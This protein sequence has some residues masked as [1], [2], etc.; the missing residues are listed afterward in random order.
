MSLA[1]RTADL[2]LRLL[3]AATLRAKVIAGNVANQN[4][5]SYKRREVTFE[6]QLLRELERGKSLEELSG[7]RPVITVDK[8]AVAR[9]DGNSVDMESEVT[10]SRENRLLYELYSSILRGQ[11]RLVETAIRS[12]R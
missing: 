7:M 6:Q 3:S 2:S 10:S 8:D 11:M 1:P 5:P 4:T 9:A 12:E